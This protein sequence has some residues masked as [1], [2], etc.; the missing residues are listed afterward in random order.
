[1]AGTFSMIEAIDDGSLQLS[2]AERRVASYIVANR[3][4]ILVMSAM[5]LAKVLGTSDATVIRTAKALGFDGLDAMRRAI[6]D[7]LHG[8]NSAADRIT[9]TI[10][11]T[12]GDLRKAF[13]DTRNIQRRAIEA[14][15]ENVSVETYIA[16]VTKM[17]GAREIAIFG[18]GP[19][20]ALAVYFATQLSRFG[21]NARP[22]TATGLFLA[23]QLLPIQRGD[24]LFIMAYGRVYLEVGVLIDH[25]NRMG[26]EKVLVTD[27]LGTKLGPRVDMAITIP[28]GKTDAFSMHTA[29]LA[30]IENIIVGI[31]TSQPKAT[32]GKLELLNQLRSELAGENAKLPA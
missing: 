17:I 13:E 18:I 29:T 12:G 28:R 30:F 31:A 6:V 8:N 32:I 16:L 15:H 5:E 20:S 22:L 26:A 2:Q 9:Q 24:L 19:T 25:A 27:M 21:L 4:Q 10:K 1:M 7:E 11:E 23:D 14:I 3:H